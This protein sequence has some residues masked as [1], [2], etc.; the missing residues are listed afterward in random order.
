M[1]SNEATWWNVYAVVGN[2]PLTRMNVRRMSRETAN[3]KANKLVADGA[4][5]AYAVKDGGR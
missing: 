4:A 1:K 3:A 2:K 5:R